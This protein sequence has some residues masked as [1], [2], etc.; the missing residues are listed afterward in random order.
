MLK[1]STFHI[2]TRSTPTYIENKLNGTITIEKKAKG[3][4]LIFLTHS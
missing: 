3:H 4:I 2:E 1:G